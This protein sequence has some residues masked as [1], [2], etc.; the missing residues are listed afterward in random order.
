MN[1]LNKLVCSVLDIKPEPPR[2]HRDDLQ[3]IA[4]LVS[5]QPLVFE[6]K[7]IERIAH[8]IVDHPRDVDLLALKIVKSRPFYKGAFWVCIAL[9]VG[10]F[11]TVRYIAGKVETD[12]SNVQK[13]VDSKYRQITNAINQTLNSKKRP[14]LSGPF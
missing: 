7:D 8:K 10:Y 3:L 6:E 11:G 2:L 4:E 1:W 14:T 9:V 12:A 13:E 5:K